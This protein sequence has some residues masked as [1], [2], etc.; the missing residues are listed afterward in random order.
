LSAKGSNEVKPEDKDKIRIITVGESTTADVLD[1]DAWPRLLEKKLNSEGYSVRIYNLA[2][3]GTWSPVIVS[4]LENQI[5]EFHPHIV[6]SMMGVNDVGTLSLALP[7]ENPVIYWFSRLRIVRVFHWAKLQLRAFFSAKRLVVANPNE[8][9]QLIV[10]EVFQLLQKR[11]AL[12]EVE[13]LIRKTISD[14]HEVSSILTAA[15][16]QYINSIEHG[17]DD[18]YVFPFRDR[19]WDL[20]PEDYRATMSE[21]STINNVETANKR[22]LK[23][24]PFLMDEFENLDDMFVAWMSGCFAKYPE[25]FN[26]EKFNELGLLINEEANHFRT[27]QKS[28]LRLAELLNKNNIRYVAMQ[29]PTERIEGIKNYFGDKATDYQ[30][31]YVE[32]RENFNRALA[33]HKYEDIFSDHFAGKWGHTTYLGHEMIVENLKPYIIKE[34]G[35][36]KA[37]QLSK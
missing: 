37:S 21:L 19:A 15:A 35:A 25:K 30:I 33:I 20:F 12:A 22:C 29:Y 36:I 28:Y 31:A 18:S 9:S 2:V 16:D 1:F 26:A 4:H 8:S 10:K 3:P 11:T 14:D 32:N 24:I 6:I 17:Q 5:E 7:E 34:I 27:T 13:A 23:V